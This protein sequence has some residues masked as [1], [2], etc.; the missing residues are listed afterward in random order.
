[1][2]LLLGTMSSDPA[3]GSC[4]TLPDGTT[5]YAETAVRQEKLGVFRYP[6][7]LTRPGR[8]FGSFLPKLMVVLPSLR[9]ASA[10][11]GLVQPKPPKLMVVLPSLR[12]ASA[13]PSAAPA[14]RRW[15]AQTGQ[16][17][18]WRHGLYKQCTNCTRPLA[19]RSAPRM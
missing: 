7:E 4:L 19:I 1:M 16:Y 3:A 17:E 10:P 11:V 5:L 9:K 14:C 6:T 12:K 2:Q 13:P 18:Q 15:R 8:K